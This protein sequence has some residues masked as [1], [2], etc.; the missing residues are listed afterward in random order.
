MTFNISNFSAHLNR[1]GTLQT[2]KFIV[3]LAAPLVFGPTATDALNEYRANSV[4]IPGV[5][6]DTQN[7]NRYGIGPQQKFPTNVTFTDID[8]TFVDTASNELWKRFASWMNQIFD[9]TGS[10]GGGQAQYRTEYKKYYQTEITIFVFDNEG[11][12]SNVLVLK[13]AFPNSLSDVSLSWSENNRLYEFTTR[14]AFREWYYE[15]YSVTRPFDSGAELGPSATAQV[16]RQRTESPRS[17]QREY[18]S[19]TEASVGRGPP[20]PQ[21]ARD[22]QAARNASTDIRNNRAGGPFAPGQTVTGAPP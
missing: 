22:A 11:R 6:L 15:G 18:S 13:E 12:Q 3:R 8:I 10:A 19:S 20:P 17:T 4:K 21:I 5:N 2:N 7:V 16:I 9:Y 1:T 14:F